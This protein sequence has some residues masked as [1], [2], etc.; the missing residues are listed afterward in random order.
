MLKKYQNIFY[1]CRKF[2]HFHFPASIFVIGSIGGALIG[3]IN[4]EKLGRKR[5][6]LID[7]VI[8]ILGKYILNTNNSMVI[9]LNNH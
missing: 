4:G 2:N 6:L 1:S 7:N 9:K 3:G 5:A 8:M